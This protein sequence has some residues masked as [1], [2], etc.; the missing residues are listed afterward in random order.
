LWEVYFG[1]HLLLKELE[2]DDL[3]VSGLSRIVMSTKGCMDYTGHVCY[4]FY[5]TM[6]DA[7]F[8]D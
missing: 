5:G 8:Y 7:P 2:G 6:D 1:T 4:S 3:V